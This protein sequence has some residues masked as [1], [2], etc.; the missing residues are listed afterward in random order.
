[1]APVGIRCPEH[2]GK[3]QGVQRMTRGIQRAS[4]E[5]TGAKATKALIG[6]N[7]AVYLAQLLTGGGVNG[8]GST[9][10]VKGVLFGPFLEQGEWWRLMTAAFLHYGPL[11]LILNMVALYWFGSLLEERIGSG[12]FLLVYLVSGLAGS[13]GALLWPNGFSTPTVGASGAIFGIL[14][15][16]LVLERQHDYVFGGSALGVILINFVFTFSISGISKGGHIGGLIG[17][18]VCALGFTRFGRGHTAY[19]RPGLLGVATIVLVGVV[20]IAIAY[21]RV[22]SYSI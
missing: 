3:P 16:G 7:V 17:G 9:I 5:G 15:A 18:I 13:A 11:H 10:Y 8:T 2:S 14:G 19:G 20:S 6:I 12:R 4:F 1:M 21:W 22:K